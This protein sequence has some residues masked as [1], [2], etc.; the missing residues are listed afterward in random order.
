MLGCIGFEPYEYP[1]DLG[2]R[3]DT[4]EYPYLVLQQ[5][6]YNPALRPDA[7]DSSGAVYY[8]STALRPQPVGQMQ[9][10]GSQE[11]GQS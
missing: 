10:G 1:E 4:D 3:I 11:S 6:Y 5:H 9:V 8:L 2:M 7:V